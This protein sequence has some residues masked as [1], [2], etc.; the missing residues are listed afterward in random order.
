MLFGG[1]REIEPVV[2]DLLDELRQEG[3]LSPDPDAVDGDGRA[4][5]L[6]PETP[7]RAGTPKPAFRR[8]V[9]EK[10]ADMKDILQLDPIHEVDQLGWPI[11]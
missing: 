4:T 9:L 3:I 7:P 8:P 2:A 11:A 6:P 5:G 10:F 1:P